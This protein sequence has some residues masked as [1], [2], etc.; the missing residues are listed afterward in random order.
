MAK[1]LFLGNIDVSPLL[2]K[3]GPNLPPLTG[4]LVPCFEPVTGCKLHIPCLSVRIP[5]RPVAKDASEGLFTMITLAR[6][7][8]R[9]PRFDVEINLADEW[10]W[11]NV[12]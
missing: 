5:Y 7:G 8:D 3:Q 1:W 11:K 9:A 6:V 2:E 4:S 10:Q 12:T